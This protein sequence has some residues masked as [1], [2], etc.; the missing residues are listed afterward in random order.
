ML[1]EDIVIK[2]KILEVEKELF[3]K[4]FNS[5]VENLLSFLVKNITKAKFQSNDFID[6]ITI[7]FDE[8][9]KLHV[10]TPYEDN[11]DTIAKVL[12]AYKI[13]IIG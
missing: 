5:D 7:N 6:T 1:I 11:R 10:V 12:K 9:G 8:E 13:R 2:D 3:I 4:K